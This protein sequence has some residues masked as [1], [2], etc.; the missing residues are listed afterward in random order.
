VIENET[1][2]AV[3]VC[4]VPGRAEEIADTM[5]ASD[6]CVREESGVGLVNVVVDL[7]DGRWWR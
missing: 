1:G 2:L 6:V 7:E 4:I 5:T 3:V